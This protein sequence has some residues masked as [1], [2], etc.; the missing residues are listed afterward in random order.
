MRSISAVVTLIVGVAVLAAPRPAVAETA[1]QRTAETVETV[2]AAETAEVVPKEVYGMENSMPTSTPSALQR[3]Y[4]LRERVNR[5]GMWTLGGWAVANFILG[6]SLY[7]IDPA[8]QA[9]HEMNVFWNTVNAGLA[10]SALIS[11]YR[12]NAPETL[13][14]EIRAQHRLEKTLLVN[15]GLDVGYIMTGFFLRQYAENVAEPRFAGW[16]SSLILQGGFLFVFDVVLAA[17][18]G[19]NRAYEDA[20]PA[21]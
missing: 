15:A 16:G 12:S 8:H 13:A 1:E 5:V 21:Q 9:F 3:S 18:H 20:V 14:A 6:G 7:F 2:E 10:V 17:I 19:R 11:S 4:Q